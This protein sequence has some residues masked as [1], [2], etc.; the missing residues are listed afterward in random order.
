[1]HRNLKSA[2]IGYNF[3]LDTT[4]AGLPVSCILSFASMH[5]KQVA[6]PLSDM[7]TQRVIYL[8]ECMD[9]A[10]DAV[11]IHNHSGYSEYLLS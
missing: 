2:W 1:M 10:Y 6:I 8:Y 3:H 9:S 4:D 11:Q 5:N 7:T